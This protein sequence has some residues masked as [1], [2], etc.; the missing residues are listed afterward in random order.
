M[1]ALVLFDLEGKTALVTGR[2]AGPG[3]AMAIALAG[4]ACIG[5]TVLFVDGG[6]M[7]R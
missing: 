4:I 3:Q 7:A 6:W 2:D 5:G 1:Q